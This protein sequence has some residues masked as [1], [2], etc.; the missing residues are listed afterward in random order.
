MNNRFSKLLQSFLTNYI[1][2]ECN[3][4]NNTKVSYSTTFYLLTQYLNNV[5]RIKPNNIEIESIDKN[6]IIE[7]LNWLETERDTSVS[8]RNQRLASIKSF[9]RYIQMNEPLLD[10]FFLIGVNLLFLFARLISYGATRFARGLATGLTFAATY[11]V[12]L[13]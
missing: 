6:M 1:I 9:Y 5:H 12:I 13:A 2:G 4:S 8:T 11:F 10:S 7:F 3:Y